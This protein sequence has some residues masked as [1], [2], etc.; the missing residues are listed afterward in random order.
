MAC[1]DVIRVRLYLSTHA[2]KSTSTRAARYLGKAHGRSGNGLRVRK[3]D[4]D[5]ELSAGH[6]VPTG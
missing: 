1:C 2:P 5:G 6:G 3:L 4:V